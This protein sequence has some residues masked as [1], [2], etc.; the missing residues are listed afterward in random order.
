LPAGLLYIADRTAATA[1]AAVA[2]YSILQSNAVN[3]QSVLWLLLKAC[4]N[5]IREGWRPGGY[6]PTDFPSS[7]ISVELRTP[8]A[9]QLLS[10]LEPHTLRH[11]FLDHRDNINWCALALSTYRDFT[12]AGHKPTIDV[13]DK[14]LACLRLP[15][16]QQAA[17]EGTATPAGGV[18]SP[19]GGVVAPAGGGGEAP[20]HEQQFLRELQRERANVEGALAGIYEVPFDKRALDLVSEAINQGLLPPLKVSV[21]VAFRDRPCIRARDHVKIC[22]R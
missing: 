22:H 4:F 1:A 17:A 12:A 6:P 21:V 15:F 9:L 5:R 7:R 10:A 3:N 19:G 14:L 20:Q 2:L 11:N 18:V 16:I 13:L 8:E